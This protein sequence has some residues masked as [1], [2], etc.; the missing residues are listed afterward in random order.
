ML[1]SVL[2]FIGSVVNLAV[3]TIYKIGVSMLVMFLVMIALSSA[4]AVML[5]WLL[6]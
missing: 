4:F 3:D 6:T 5:V 2:A 1:A